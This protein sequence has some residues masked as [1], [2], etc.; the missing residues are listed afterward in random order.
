MPTLKQ[1]EIDRIY[2]AIRPRLTLSSVGGGS[3][4][5]T[6]PPH[7][8]PAS[9]ISFEPAGD[10]A[11]DDVQEGMEEL[12]EEKLA[13]SGLQ[14]MLGTLQMNSFDIT[15]IDEATFTGTAV[16]HDPIRIDFKTG[17]ETLIRYLD[18]IEF[19]LASQHTTHTEGALHWNT[20][21]DMLVE[22]VFA[23]AGAHSI[24]LAATYV[25]VYNAN[26]VQLDAGRAV[27][28]NGYGPGGTL[29]IT[30]ATSETDVSGVLLLNIAD[31][32]V[33]WIC[34]RGLMFSAS[35][36]PSLG[37]TQYLNDA[38]G[39]GP[40]PVDYEKG[41]RR[42]VRVGHALGTDDHFIVDIEVVHNVA[43]LSDVNAPVI[44]CGD[45]LVRT[46]STNSAC[47]QWTASGLWTEVVL[48]FGATDV[49]SDMKVFSITGDPRVKLNSIIT[50]MPSAKPF[51]PRQEDEAE[52]DMF[53][54]S[55]IPVS[56]QP[57]QDDAPSEFRAY[58]HSL[59]GRVVGQYIFNYTVSNAAAWNC[60]APGGE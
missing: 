37:G 18:T 34:T 5:G 12:A 4:A 28:G 60:V 51:P 9:A 41:C 27:V 26:G 36:W 44:A 6:V 49:P 47:E 40:A 31:G 32:A 2:T 24:P 50:M 38:G 55:C 13:R 53:A 17:T 54:C 8:H 33:G 22:D 11:G 21:L 30:Y 57:T 42:T 52:F 14:T 48:D 46:V 58:I 45:V 29:S 59:R 35:A 39:Y 25:K 19:D 15:G 43:Q 3:G 23:T 1:R 10:V 7:T 20:D 16:I 56:E